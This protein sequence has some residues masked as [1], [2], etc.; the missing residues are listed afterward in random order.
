MKEQALDAL[1]ESLSDLDSLVYEGNLK[2]AQ[3]WH[4]QMLINLRKAGDI[5]V[6]IENQLRG[7]RFFADRYSYTNA[8][9]IR[10]YTFNKDKEECDFQLKAAIR[11]IEKNGYSPKYVVP[12]ISWF[13]RVAK[14]WR[15]LVALLTFLLTLL[16]GAY[17]WGY[18]HG[19]SID[20][21]MIELELD[22]ANAEI[23]VLK[24]SIEG[25]NASID[26]LRAIIISAN[27]GNKITQGQ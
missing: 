13:E 3:R 2:S 19:K 11:Y 15:G 5:P 14:S 6:Q 24:D 8:S 25:R 22:K 17:K 23:Q 4:Q 18:N 27:K 9:N 20:V 10:E 16:G 7:H 21:K 26:S 1:G 12:E